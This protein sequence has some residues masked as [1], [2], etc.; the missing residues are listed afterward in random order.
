TGQ[1]FEV[2]CDLVITVGFLKNLIQD[3]TGIP[4]NNQKLK[5]QDETLADHRKLSDYGIQHMSTVKL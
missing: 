1:K 2:S 3:K 4:P 5:Y